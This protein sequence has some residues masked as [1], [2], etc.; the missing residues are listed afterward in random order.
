MSKKK[1]FVFSEEGLKVFSWLKRVCVLNR[2]SDLMRLSLGTLCDLMIAIEKGEKIVIQSADG[3]EKQYHPFL[4]MDAPAPPLEALE[5][6]R[7]APKMGAE[8]AL[9]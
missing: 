1:N 7:N 6:F 4:E 3:T 2:D 9:A 8:R 5:K